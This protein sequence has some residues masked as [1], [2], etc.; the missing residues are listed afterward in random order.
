[1]FRG[2][3]IGRNF[4]LGYKASSGGLKNMMNLDVTASEGFSFTNTLESTGIIKIGYHGIKKL[5]TMFISALAS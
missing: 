4:Q 3:I 2:S 1:M 5:E